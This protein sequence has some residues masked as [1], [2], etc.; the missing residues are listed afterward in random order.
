M[1]D[2]AFFAN[3]T[4]YAVAVLG[5]ADPRDEARYADNVEDWVAYAEAWTLQQ[6]GAPWVEIAEWP[7]EIPLIC[8]NGVLA[9]RMCARFPQYPNG[10]WLHVLVD[11]HG[12]LLGARIDP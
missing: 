1:I 9:Y 5:D 4:W 11:Q 7:G 6:Y 10:V 12:T 2:D 8:P 3:P